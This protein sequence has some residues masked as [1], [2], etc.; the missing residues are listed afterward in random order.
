MTW[1][2][3]DDARGVLAYERGL[4]EQRAIVAFNA[5]G[6]PHEISVAAE[7]T[8]RAVY[9]AVDA[10][11]AADGVLTTGL[12]PRTARVWIRQGPP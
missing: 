3:A 4:G 2:L 7:G 10:V 11:V 12:P 9:P 1:L 5:S 8:Y 6:E